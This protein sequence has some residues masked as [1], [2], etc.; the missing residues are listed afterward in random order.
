MA[1]VQ[2]ELCSDGDGNTVQCLQHHGGTPPQPRRSLRAWVLGWNPGGF[3][4]PVLV[5]QP[6]HVPAAISSCGTLLPWDTPVW[7]LGAEQPELCFCWLHGT[8]NTKA[9]RTTGVFSLANLQSLVVR[10]I[11]PFLLI[12][13]KQT[14][15]CGLG[16]GVGVSFC[17]HCFSSGWI[18]QWH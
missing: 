5:V 18:K 14:D 16:G 4:L 9:R 2:Y 13:C 12:S 6:R 3:L 7:V 15:E 1:E 10:G 11:S 17:F 8:P